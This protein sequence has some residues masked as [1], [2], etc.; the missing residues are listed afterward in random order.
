MFTGIIIRSNSNATNLHSIIIQ[1]RD[2]CKKKEIDS[3]ISESKEVEQV[4]SELINNRKASQSKIF[5]ENVKSNKLK[6]ILEIDEK[7][8]SRDGTS[9]EEKI[10]A[11]MDRI[12]I[13][14]DTLSS[15]HNSKPQNLDTDE[16]P[17]A[18]TRTF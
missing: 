12:N 10:R 6:P 7:H 1:L 17:G 14:S 16:E 2:L 11:S 9:R 4:D 3:K 18:L 5:Q 15:K 13:K 8:S